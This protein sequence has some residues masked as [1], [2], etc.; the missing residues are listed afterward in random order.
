[1]VARSSCMPSTS[2]ITGIAASLSSPIGRM[3]AT[4]TVVLRGQHDHGG[5]D[6]VDA[7]AL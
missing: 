7:P 3:T 4:G 6:R 5:G 1:M 2:S